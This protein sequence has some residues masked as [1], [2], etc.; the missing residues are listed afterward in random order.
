MYHEN[1]CSANCDRA[2]C[3]QCTLNPRIS[4]HTIFQTNSHRPKRSGKKQQHQPCSCL[5]TSDTTHTRLLL[6]PTGYYVSYARRVDERERGRPNPN[7]GDPFEPAGRA[8]ILIQRCQPALKIHPQITTIPP[9]LTLRAEEGEW[10]AWWVYFV[11]I[12]F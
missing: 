5:P 6:W 11:F 9:L 4:P 1:Q 2:A 10:F 8:S 7:H 12:H 3:W